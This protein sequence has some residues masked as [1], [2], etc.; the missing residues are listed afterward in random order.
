MKPMKEDYITDLLDF[1]GLEYEI[2]K[3]YYDWSYLRVFKVDDQG[4]P[5]YLC[6]M[7]LHKGMLYN[8][9]WYFTSLNT[10]NENNIWR[11]RWIVA[12][13]YIKYLTEE[14]YESIINRVK[15]KAEDKY[16]LK[17]KARKL[18]EDS[19]KRKKKRKRIEYPSLENFLGE[20]IKIIMRGD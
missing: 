17:L 19:D 2:S 14:D 3:G 12:R 5:Y 6:R 20:S 4:L 7:K 18:L 16:Q 9:Q 11:V 13:D 15:H 8:L 10:D 1:I